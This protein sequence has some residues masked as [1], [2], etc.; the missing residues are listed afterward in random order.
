MRRVRW[1]GRIRCWG[2]LCSRS[3]HRYTPRRATPLRI[4]SHPIAPRRLATQH[5]DWFCNLSLRRCT[6]RRHATRRNATPRSAASRPASQRLVLQFASAARRSAAPCSAAPRSAS[7][8]ATSQR[9]IRI[10]R[11]HE[12][13]RDIRTPDLQWRPV[14]RNRIPCVRAGRGWPGAIGDCEK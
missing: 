3:P 5:I 14:V 11:S 4:A 2:R 13:Q 8:H 7:P 12:D 1:N 6:P 10:P 9:S